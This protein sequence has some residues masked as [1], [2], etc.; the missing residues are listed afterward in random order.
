[1]QLFSF[2]LTFL[3]VSSI[4]FF[5][6]EKAPNQLFS[7]CCMHCLPK[8]PYLVIKPTQLP[9]NDNKKVFKVFWADETRIYV[10]GIIEATPSE[11]IYYNSNLFLR[12]FSISDKENAIR[13]VNYKGRKYNYTINKSYDKT[14]SE[15]YKVTFFNIY[16]YIENTK[17]ILFYNCKLMQIEAFVIADN[18]QSKLNKIYASFGDFYKYES[19]FI[20]NSMYPPGQPH[21][22]H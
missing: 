2:I 20:F 12:L 11:L 8:E 16:P 3:I 13:I 5:A 7:S 6:Q 21:H 1:M 22:L 10:N 9:S 17:I 19:I 14:Q 15:I 18:S 4:K